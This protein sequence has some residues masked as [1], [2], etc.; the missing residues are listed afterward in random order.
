MRKEKDFGPD[1]EGNCY[2]CTGCINKNINEDDLKDIQKKIK[3][4]GEDDK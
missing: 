1:C 4:A 3:E 2:P